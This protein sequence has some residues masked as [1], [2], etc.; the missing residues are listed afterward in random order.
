MSRTNGMTC[1]VLAVGVGVFGM[2]ASP[3]LAGG[4]GVSFGYSS[5]PSYAYGGYYPP[6]VV[7][8]PAYYSGCTTYVRHG[9]YLMYPTGGYAVASCPPPVV[10]YPQP[11]PVVYGGRSIH[12][13]GF[14]YSNPWRVSRPVRTYGHRSYATRT[15]YVSPGPVRRGPMIAPARSHRGWSRSSHSFVRPRHGGHRR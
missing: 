8:P 7:S 15:V 4:F 13:G 10:Y 5:G 9:D 1:V 11:A 12:V 3:A 2:S 14:Y 6:V